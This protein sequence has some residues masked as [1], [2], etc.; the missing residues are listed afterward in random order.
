MIDRRQLLAGVAAAAAATAMPGIGPAKPVTAGAV[1][2][3][4]PLGFTIYDGARDIDLPPDIAVG[5][6]VTV[7][8]ASEATIHVRLGPGAIELGERSTL[9]LVRIDDR[10]RRWWIKRWD[11]EPSDA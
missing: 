10:N 7:V 11:T 1:F 3:D 6:S 2:V 8:N 9:T 4:F 5:Q